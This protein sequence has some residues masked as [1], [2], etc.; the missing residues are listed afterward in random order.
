MYSWPA[1]SA[2]LA[3]LEKTAL[4][5]QAQGFRVEKTVTGLAPRG[6][7]GIAE[8]AQNQPSRRTG[9]LD[10]EDPTVYRCTWPC[11]S[12]HLR[13]CILEQDTSVAK[14]ICDETSCRR[15]LYLSPQNLLAK[16]GWR[17]L[18]LTIEWK[19]GTELDWAA[20]TESGELERMPI[21][22]KQMKICQHSG[23]QGQYWLDKVCI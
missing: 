13:S 5:G 3:Q 12:K 22:G 11:F 1:I 19:P 21:M 9:A 20:Q 14:E 23:S 16:V 7:R 2:G 17:Q 4:S 15:W 6:H 18:S 8:K 10:E